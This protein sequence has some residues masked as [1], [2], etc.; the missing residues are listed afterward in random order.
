[1]GIF[2]KSKKSEMP[3][4]A[5]EHAVI[6]QFNYM[7]ATLDELS[8]LEEQLEKAIV[9]ADAG[10]FDGNEVALD[11]R[12]TLLYMYGPD[13]DRLYAAIEPVLMMW[14]A[15]S[16]ARVRLRYGPPGGDTRQKTVVLPKY[17]GT[18]Q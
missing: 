16:E 7:P 1:M 12:D 14:D 8:A 15:L 11:G 17:S 6:V 4:A 10:E 5:P 13:A 2:D 9:A 3:V 18:R